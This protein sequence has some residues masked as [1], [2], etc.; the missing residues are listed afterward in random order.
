M[1]G[2]RVRVLVEDGVDLG[3]PR[4]PKVE[5]R[6]EEGHHGYE[7]AGRWWGGGAGSSRSP[8]WG[9]C[10]RATG[11]VELLASCCG[12]LRVSLCER[13]TWSRAKLR[14]P[15]RS[16]A[17]QSPPSRSRHTAQTRAGALL[18]ASMTALIPPSRRR[19]RHPPRGV[20]HA[21]CVSSSLSL[22]RP[23]PARSRVG[24]RCSDLLHALSDSAQQRAK[25]RLIAPAWLL[26]RTTLS[27]VMLSPR[28]P[29]SERNITAAKGRPN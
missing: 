1:R 10:A 27:P 22:A 3:R 11:C 16:Q 20:P 2:E 29:E 23:F 24:R 26:R 6:R 25:A 15:L 8:F 12:A 4:P 14:S 17:P 7:V 13:A 19:S 9:V 18:C 21:N 5:R 28:L